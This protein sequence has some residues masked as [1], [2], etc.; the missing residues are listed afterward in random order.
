MIYEKMPFTYDVNKLK[1]HLVNF[2]LPLPKESQSSNF[3]GWSVTSSNGDY[4]D[5][6]FQGQNIIAKHKTGD[7]KTIAEELKKLSIP[8]PKDYNKPTEICHGY[9]AEVVNDVAKKGL[10]PGRVRIICLQAEGVSSWHQD[11]PSQYYGVRLHIPIETNEGCFFESEEGFAHLAAD[12][13]AYLLRVNRLHR[14]VNRGQSH[15]YHLVM[16]VYDTSGVS[17]YHQMTEKDQ[18]FMVKYDL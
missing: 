4:K 18:E 5:G 16:D 3:G 6:W 15:R 1:A 17:N 12:G 2:V 11:M 9:L 8:L 13:S 14:V 7:I 10:R